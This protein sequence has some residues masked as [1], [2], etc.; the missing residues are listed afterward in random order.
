[1]RHIVVELEPFAEH[2]LRVIGAMFQGG[3]SEQPARE[4]LVVSLEMQ[5]HVRRHFQ[6]KADSVGSTGLLHV[7]RDSIQDLTRSSLLCRNE[8]L[9][10]HVEHQLVGHE[11]TALDELLNGSAEFSLLRNMVAE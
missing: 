6:L 7:A 2:V 10:H 5:R 1:M 8:R 3:T 4:L 9:P 11:L